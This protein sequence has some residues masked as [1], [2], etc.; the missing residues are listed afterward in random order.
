MKK[1][2]QEYLQILRSLQGDAE[3]RRLAYEYIR[4]SDCYVYGMPAPVS[5]VPVFYTPDEVRF[6]EDVCR[7]TH[8]ILCKV[9]RHYLESETYRALFH[10]PKETERLILLPCDYD[11]LLPMA[12]FDFFLS[13]DDLSF[14]FCEFN[15]DG[16]SAMSRTQI[17]C[18]AAAQS[19]TFRRFAAG[20]RAEPFETFDSWAEELLRTYAGDRNS[21]EK[22]NVLITDFEDAVTMSDVTRYLDAFARRGV[23][24]RFVDIR[25]LVFDGEALRDPS[26]GMRFHVVYR[27]AVT[28][29]IVRN[30][31]A[32]R[33]LIDAVEAR[34]V[35]LIGHFRTT[36]IHSKMINVALLDEQ[37][38]ALLT[39]EEREFVREHVLPTFR[40]R[41]DE[42]RV[43][44][45]DV[46]HH[47][48]QWILKPEDDYDSHGVYAGTDLTQEEWAMRVRETLDSGYVAM[49]YHEPPVCEIALTDPSAQS[50]PDCGIVRW[51]CL[52]GAF[53]FNGKLKGFFSMMGDRGVINER[54][55]AVSVP[56]FRLPED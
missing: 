42:P 38:H 46:L 31:D 2:R 55:G 56:S 44:V 15:A 24:A 35:C 34:R 8:R 23:P 3:G 19:E 30:M 22:P 49:R 37:T 18:E 26:D 53:A 4:Q 40:F 52:T 43:S 47:R 41:S 16:A 7:T 9:I 51:G 12:R 10:F 25:K 33:A 27:R 39:G 28:S 45:E 20:H 21:V 50:A 5:F 48:K 14:R 36:V 6:L 29:D 11:D 1:E 54:H 32:C 17:G 13:E